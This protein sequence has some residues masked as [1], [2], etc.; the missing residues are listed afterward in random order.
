MAKNKKK[1]SIVFNKIKNFAYTLND[2]YV[3]IAKC[4]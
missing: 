2:S 1:Q 4:L 3:V